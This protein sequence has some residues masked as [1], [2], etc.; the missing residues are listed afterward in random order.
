MMN[1][2]IP[3]GMTGAPLAAITGREQPDVMSEALTTGHGR[4]QQV[5]T[6]STDGPLSV[7]TSGARVS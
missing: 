4:F 2:P 5:I 1:V 3:G 7:A 6:R